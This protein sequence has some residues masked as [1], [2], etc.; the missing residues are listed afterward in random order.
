MWATTGQDDRQVAN[1]SEGI[2]KKLKE[3]EAI[4]ALDF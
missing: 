2:K 3:I 1:C 4:E